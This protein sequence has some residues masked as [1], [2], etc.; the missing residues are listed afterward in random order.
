MTFLSSPWVSK[1]LLQFKLW[2]GKLWETTSLG[3]PVKVS[4]G[5]LPNYRQRGRQMPG[6]WCRKCASF[7][8]VLFVLSLFCL[9]SFTLSV[10]LYCIYPF[11]LFFL[12]FFISSS[13]LAS[14]SFCILLLFFGS[15]S[16]VLI[17]ISA[18]LLFTFCLD[19]LSV[20]LSLFLCVHFSKTT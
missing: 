19:V 5:N 4:P 17:V 10:F 8:T 12:V 9:S 15:S 1:Q 20:I 14:P 16:R 13:F 18:F 3:S 11:F 7:F 6:Q 2:A